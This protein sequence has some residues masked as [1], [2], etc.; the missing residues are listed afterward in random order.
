[1][2]HLSVRHLLLVI[3]LLGFF[4]SSAC[5]EQGIIANPGNLT[6]AGSTFSAVNRTILL[7]AEENVTDLRFVSTDLTTP[8]GTVF[9]SSFV[10][11]TIIESSMANGSIQSIPVM[12]NL[13]GDPFAHGNYSGELWISDSGG[14]KTTIPVS[15]VLKNGWVAPF[16]LLLIVVCI[17]MAVYY[18]GIGG[19]ER[20]EILKATATLQLRITHDEDLKKRYHNEENPFNPALSNGV[21]NTFD[22]VN[23]GAIKDAGKLLEDTQKLWGK[24]TTKRFHWMTEFGNY[25][26][27][28][29]HLDTDQFKILDDPVVKDLGSSDVRFIC[30]ELGYLKKE[31]EKVWEAD[32]PDVFGLMIVAENTK[33]NSYLDLYSKLAGLKN[34]CPLC[35]EDVRK[36]LYEKFLNLGKDA[37]LKPLATDIEDAQKLYSGRALG[38]PLA[39]GKMYEEV[40]L[41]QHS[42]AEGI[43]DLGAKASFRLWLYGGVSFLILLTVLFIVGYNQ[44]YVIKPTFGSPEDYITLILWGL[45]V[46]PFS[47][48]VSKR[49][50]K[51]LFPDE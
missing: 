11:A 21:R 28:A 35:P 41:I 6:L 27:L 30:E 45:L 47:D 4:V 20:D 37:D 19:K 33:R 8:E 18:Y 26:K 12:F 14:G 32:S 42:G 9:P 24:W 16:F 46:G 13:P 34:N 7:T 44:L 23:D 22:K 40:P 29:E 31:Y 10:Q 43:L 49:T 51:N 38:F 48:T 25:E 3:I 17:S 39:T 2:N 36:K 5:A 1:M 50:Q 15:L